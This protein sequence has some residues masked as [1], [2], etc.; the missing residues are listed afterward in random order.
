MLRVAIIGASGYTG[1]DSVE[2][3]LRHQQAKAVYLTALPEECG[4]LSDTFGQFKGRCELDIEPLDL[5]K[6]SKAADVALCCLPH[7]VSM[8]FVPNLLKAGLKVIDFSAD[9]RIKD[10]KVYEKYYQPHSDKENLKHAVYGLCE[11]YRDK[12]KNAKLVA[13]PGCF[14]TG[15]MLGTAPLLKNKLV[16]PSII[17][18]AVTGTSG[19]GKN[20]SKNFHFPNM[21]ENFFAYSIGK[22]RHQPEMEQIA[23]EI[24]GKSIDVLFQPHVGPFDVGILSTIY[25]QPKEKMTNEKLA[26]LYKDFYKN[27]HFVQVLNTAPMLKDIAKTNYCHIYPA[28]CKDK[29]V[30][31]TAIDNLI[32][33]ASGQAIQNMNIMYNFDETAGLL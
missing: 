20:P 5:K 16:E 23:G 13:N 2:I 7:K 1:A 6:L 24:A 21:N 29:I 22:H 28:V 8:E 10:I 3:L 26:E 9:Y 33:G 14:P 18:N 17:V 12:I 30:V 27:E 15:F 11:L 19:A 32:K 31:F 25:C 4:K